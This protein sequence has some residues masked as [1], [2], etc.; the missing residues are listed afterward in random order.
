[1]KKTRHLTTYEFLDILQVEFVVT[2]L[3]RKIYTKKKDKTFFT[4]VLSKKREKIEDISSRNN[5]PSIFDDEY[6]KEL[7]YSKVYTIFGL[8]DFHYTTDE[9][10]QEYKNKDIYYY[11]TLGSQFRVVDSNPI[12]VG[13]L[14]QVNL[15]NNTC[16]LK[17]KGSPET[18]TLHLENIS[19]II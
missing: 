7:Y 10:V 3:R 6:T 12:M 1:M 4:K 9:Q 14:K 19:R 5:L 17:I 15:D 16:T 11:Y 13:V 18:K 8:P 2:E